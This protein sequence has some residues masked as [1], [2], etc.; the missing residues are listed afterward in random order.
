M[1]VLDTDIVSYGLYHPENYP[2]LVLYLETTPKSQQWIS[3]TTAHQLVAFR[4]HRLTDSR[5]QGQADITANYRRFVEILRDLRQ[6]QILDFEDVAYQQFLRMGAVR[7]SVTD[8]RIAATALANGYH[9]VT[10][11]HQDFELIKEACPEL[12]IDDWIT[13]PP[14]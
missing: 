13:S 2:N 10:N 1:Y 4:V 7:V 6:F 14:A 12:V 11:N 8:R 9:V 5:Q 3:A